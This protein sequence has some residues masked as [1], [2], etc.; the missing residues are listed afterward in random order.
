MKRNF[1]SYIYLNVDPSLCNLASSADR[2]SDLL[3]LRILYDRLT[4]GLGLDILLVGG[5][6]VILLQLGLVLNLLRLVLVSVFALLSLGQVPPH[7]TY[8]S[9]NFPQF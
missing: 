9:A 1:E 8:D 4:S 6:V 5:A 2:S 7:L 3:F